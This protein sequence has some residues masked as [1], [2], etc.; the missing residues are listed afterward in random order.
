[1]SSSSSGAAEPVEVTEL[2]DFLGATPPFTELSRHHLARVARNLDITYVPAD[3]CV[4]DLGDTPETLFLVRMGAVELQNTSGTLVA[5]LGEGEFFA[6]PSLLTGDPVQ[7]RVTTIE[8]CLFYLIP[9]ADFDAV[10]ATSDAVDRFFAR[11]HSN[12]I[13]DAVLEKPQ[14]TPLAT[15]V[16]SI[17]SRAP[18][19]A[20]PDVSIRSAAQAMREERVSCLLLCDDDTLVGLVTD[21]DLRV[22]VLAAGV[23][24]ER[25]VRDI[26]TSDPATIAADQYAFEALL[27]MSRRNVHH[28]PVRTGETLAGVVTITDLMRLQA[29]NPVYLVGEV[30]KQ[31]DLDGLVDVSRRIPQVVHDL[32]Q[33]GARS[34][35]VARVVTAVS[36]ALTQRLLEMGEAKLGPPPVPYA[37]MA[38]GSQARFEQTA[39]SDQDNALLLSDQAD[40]SAHDDYFLAL[41]EFVCDGLNACGYEY[42]PGGVMATTDDWRQPLAA[43]KRTFRAWIQEPTPKA[44]MH[45]TIFFDLRH[46]HGAAGLTRSLQS[47]VLDQTAQ[48]SI[49]LACLTTNALEATPPLGFFRQ[50][51]LD[52]H[53][54]EEDTLDL[55]HSGVVPIIDIARIYALARGISAVNTRKRLQQLADAGHMSPDDATDLQDA[56]AFIARVRLEHQAAQI[57][58]GETPTHYVSPNA[59]SDF[60]RRHLKDAFRIVSTMQSALAQRYQTHFLS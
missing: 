46:V 30:W 38:L 33:S 37:W 41:A 18:I 22:R 44:L 49:F 2:V 39:H 54:G 60:E 8:D 31:D 52:E 12:R 47:F 10:R 6:Y 45:S 26:M 42:C 3:T 14:E 5:R 13:R 34:H 11:A 23:D 28:L 43:W 27:T 20:S 19:T 58:R 51:V 21:R 55:K 57:G 56:H 35:D 53:G 24:P 9:E 32:V 40:L 36:D 29:D 25:P 15:P 17:L 4:L 48:N 16:R 1:M 7:R 59:L 50:F